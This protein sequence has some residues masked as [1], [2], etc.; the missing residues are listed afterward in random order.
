M[1]RALLFFLL[2]FM[3]SPAIGEPIKVAAVIS[4]SG[5]IAPFG[6]AFRK[7]IELG[8]KELGED[9]FKL[10]FEDDKS[11][12]KMS[13]IDSTK[14][15]LA[16]KRPDV[17]FFTAVN[18]GV[19][20]AP[21]INQAKVL[22]L[23]LL[24]SNRSITRMGDYIYGFGY[25]NEDVGRKMAHF[26]VGREVAERVGLIYAFD[27][28]SEIVAASFAERLKSLG[29]SIVVEEQVSLN[30]SDFRGIVNK[31]KSNGVT[32]VYFPLYKGALLS[33]I[34][35]AR[36]QKLSASLLTA[37]GLTEVEL[38]QLGAMAEGIV[39]THGYLEDPAFLEK[40]RVHFGEVR[41]DEVN[42][43]HVALGYDAIH[44]VDI[45][46]RSAEGRPISSAAKIKF[47]GVAG[48]V[49][50]SKSRLSERQQQLF[51]IR[52]GQFKPLSNPEIETR[53]ISY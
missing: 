53:I 1:W 3:Q 8:V 19:A 37:E 34:R 36:E 15:L 52:N 13:L 21:I 42:L 23:I 17:F 26:A 45:L 43:S 12:D 46:A 44:Y 18:S 7:G 27:E 50:Y 5:E 10:F 22:S 39:V 25:S 38:G 20:V 35:R 40:Y 48:E 14:S 30:E 2:G 24:D 31:L 4:L 9:K 29:G 11:L 49:D 32:A 51:E 6:V 47:K 41:S 33:F 16:R 28:W